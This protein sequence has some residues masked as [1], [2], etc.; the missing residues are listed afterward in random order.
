[1]ASIWKAADWLEREVFDLMGIGFIGH[2]NLVK[3]VT[4]E[5]LEGHPH[6]KDFPLTYEI[7]RFSFNKDKP[8]EVVDEP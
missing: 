3:I 8:P 1:V 7:P 2:P 4:P 6:R 5:D